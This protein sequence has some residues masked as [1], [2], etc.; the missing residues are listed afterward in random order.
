M[1]IGLSAIEEE[2]RLAME[3]FGGKSPVITHLNYLKFC[4]LMHTRTRGN[5]KWRR[6]LLSVL[7]EMGELN[8]ESPEIILASTDE[9]FPDREY[10]FPR[11]HYSV[12]YANAYKRFKGAFRS[13]LRFS[14]H[15]RFL[16]NRFI[17]VVTPGG[18]LVYYSRPQPLS[19]ALVGNKD[20][21]KFPFHPVLAQ[22]TKLK[23]K[24]SGEIAFRWRLG[25]RTPRDVYASNISGHYLPKEWTCRELNGLLRNVLRLEK[26]CSLVTLANDG[27]CV[28]GPVAFQLQ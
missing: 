25:D 7:A 24:V 28:T 21:S 16:T 11:R 8:F 12:D 9:P 5:S 26:S 17:Y 2:F 10:C 23:V 3:D 1:H 13:R 6:R 19:V 22:K 15:K 27:V 14:R 20:Q 18:T 4:W